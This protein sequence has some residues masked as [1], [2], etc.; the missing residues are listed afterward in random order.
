MLTRHYDVIVVGLRPGALV[1]AALLAKRGLRVLAVDHPRPD[2][3]SHGPCRFPS[4]DH[5]LMGF[6]D[7]L[8]M[9]AVLDELTVHPGR[10]RA[11]K[12]GDPSLQVVL[13]HARVDVVP[14]PE[15]YAAEL[16]R[17]LGAEADTLLDV[18]EALSVEAGNLALAWQHRR[19]A[20]PSPSLLQ[21]VGYKWGKERPLFNS[22]PLSLGEL[23][24]R[25]D[26]SHEAR[27]LLMAQI[28]AFG[29]QQDP[30]AL[31]LPVAA[32]IL[33]SARAGIYRAPETLHPLRELL[34]HRLRELHGAVSADDRVQ[35]IQ[36]SWGR[37]DKVVL[38]GHDQPYECDHLI[39]GGRWEDLVAALPADVGKRYAAPVEGIAPRGGRLCVHLVVAAEGVPEGM[40][41]QVV[42]VA[43][44]A[45]PLRDGN[46][47]V[48]SASP[49]GDL[50]WAPADRRTLTLST[51]VDL[52]GLDAE[53]QRRIAQ[54][55]ISHLRSFVP[56]LD[57][58]LHHALTPPVEA[59]IPP[60]RWLW[61][62]EDMAAA[63]PRDM[64]PGPRLPHWNLFYCGRGAY[65]LLGME[66]E[67][68]AGVLAV[69]AVVGSRG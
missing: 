23:L 45:A 42:S 29:Y 60:E 7:P 40:C 59:P 35:A 43:D 65:P 46:L 52:E 61:S 32:H 19:S 16:R 68:A 15:R 44:P 8:L 17:E 37:A 39:W 33:L 1:A 4:H 55:M 18:S 64:G 34:L 31:P 53:R 3:V 25:F 26:L 47:L 11:V 10:R 28:A 30:A 36:C 20:L 56:F 14:D 22:Q 50:A 24:E 66:G 6:D 27:A 57:P 49:P 2:L 69:D 38:A 5:Q 13:P 21:R 67:I 51:P 9:A 54:G 63:F 48:V 62:A 41:Q 12:R 58:H